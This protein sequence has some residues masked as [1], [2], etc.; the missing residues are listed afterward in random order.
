[1]PAWPQLLG[2]LAEMGSCLG[3]S[4]PLPQPELSNSKE[5]AAGQDFG[6]TWVLLQVGGGL[7]GLIP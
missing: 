6:G 1:M 3:W 2:T 4:Q 5:E 7:S